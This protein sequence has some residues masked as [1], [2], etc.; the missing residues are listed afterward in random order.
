MKETIYQKVYAIHDHAMG[1]LRSMKIPPYPGNYKKYFDQLFLEMADEELRKDLESAEKKVVTP[2]KDDVTA[3]LDLAQRSV[4]SFVESH[5]D[6]ASVAQVQRDYIENVPSNIVERCIS[7]IEGLN[8]INQSMSDELEKAQSKIHSLTAELHNAVE[9]LTTDP[10]TKVG[11]R[12]GFT[13]DLEIL[14]ASGQNKRLSMILMMIDVDDFKYL[15]EEY[16][17]MAGDKV[18]YFIAQAIK[19]MIRTSDKLYRYGG[20]EFM[21]IMNRVDESQAMVLA[22]KIRA[23]IEQTNLLYSGKTIKVTISIG[24][25][26]HQQGDSYDAMMGR[27]EK[28]L[29]CAKKS[30]K[31]CAFQYDWEQ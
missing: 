23:S 9:S 27:V 2:P 4:M 25:T 8:E 10:L 3:Y 24:L 11:N 1:L 13:D 12:K 28:A 31:N 22:D 15:N 29:Y 26:L 21:L 17:H 16:G 18:L 14:T 20:E 19:S 5:A 30:N 7:F 6:I